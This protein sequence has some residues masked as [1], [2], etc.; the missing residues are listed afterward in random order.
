MSPQGGRTEVKAATSAGV[1]SVTVGSLGVKDGDKV[2]V[3]ETWEGPLNPPVLGTVRRSSKFSEVLDDSGKYLTGGGNGKKLPISLP[4]APAKLP[5]GSS[6]VTAA[7]RA[8]T[9][10]IDAPVS[11]D[12]FENGAGQ[13]DVGPRNDRTVYD[14]YRDGG[15]WHARHMEGPVVGNTSYSADTVANLARKVATS[16]NVTGAVSIEDE[17]GTGRSIT[18]RF[19]HT[20]KA[21]AAEK[22][23]AAAFTLGEAPQSVRTAA[24]AAVDTRELT[25]LKGL[26]E[27]FHIDENAPAAWRR[28]LAQGKVEP[29][30][31]S[32]DGKPLYRV[33]GAAPAAAP[34]R[35]VHPAPFNPATAA[36]AALPPRREGEGDA[37]YSIRSAVSDSVAETLLRGYTIPGLKAMA[38]DAGIPGGGSMS[39]TQLIAAL[40]LPRRRY[41]DSVAV[42]R[43]NR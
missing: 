2:L 43:Q 31:G 16:H 29:T 1:P 36:G 40:M 30:G 32:Y 12:I 19:E 18:Q 37:M 5:A 11:V 39:K 42:E 21:T 15:Q 3:H 24:S 14:V 33:A 34:G 10:H 41:W 6:A 13:L 27:P 7:D 17:R 28:L 22:K 25:Y 20:V 35:T 8:I 26:G 4:E 38:R 9:S 23:A